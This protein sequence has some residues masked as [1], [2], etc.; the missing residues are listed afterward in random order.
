MTLFKSLV[1]ILTLI[2]LV[3]C[4]NADRES[5]LQDQ[6]LSEYSI[7][8]SLIAFNNRAMF[9]VGEI[10]LEDVKFSDNNQG[11]LRQ[12]NEIQLFFK[13]CSI[14]DRASQGTIR[15]ERFHIK[16]ELGENI[17]WKRSD[18]SSEISN[19]ITVNSGNCLRWSQKVPEFDFYAPSVNIALHFEIESLSGQLGK[20]VKRIG[21][22]PWDMHRRQ[23][24][25]S[26]FFDLTDYNRADWHSGQWVVGDQIVDALKGDLFDRTAELRFDS[27]SIEPVERTSVNVA[28]FNRQA[29]EL[30][31]SEEM[32]RRREIERSL[33]E[34]R[35]GLHINVNM[36]A[37]PVV[38]NYDSGGNRDRTPITS[39]RFKVYMNLIAR[40]AAD[41]NERHLLS[42]NVTDITGRSASFIWRM[43]QD[44]RLITSVPLIL[45][46]RTEFGR[47]EL[48]LKVVPVDSGLRNVKPY[49][50]VFDL[51]QYDQWVRRQ[52]T[53]F[54]FD[55]NYNPLDQ[56]SYDQYVNSVD[57]IVDDLRTVREID[58]FYFGPLRM[59]FIRIMPGET[60]TDRTLQYSVSTCVEHGLYGSRVGPGLQFDIETEDKGRTH[61]MR[62]Q[63]N[64]EGCLVWFGFLSHKFYRKEV[65][66][67]KTA[68]VRFAGTKNN[69]SSSPDNNINQWEETINRY[70]QEFTYYMNPWDEKFTFGWDENEMP[71]GYADEIA[72]QRKTAPVSQLFIAD[73]RYETM[74]F[75]YAIDKYLNLKVKKAVLFKAFPYVL[76][77]NSIVYG[78]MGTQKLRDGVYLMKVALQKD[79]LDPAA[80]GVR[81]YDRHLRRPYQL[82]ESNRQE[83]LTAEDLEAA[84]GAEYVYERYDRE[85]GTVDELLP[86]GVESHPGMGYSDSD[87]D[88]VGD[89]VDHRLLTESELRDTK[90]E[91]IS[92]QTKLVRVLGGMIIT[93]IEFEIDDLRLMRIRN[94]F[95]IQLETIDEHKLRMATV[96]DHVLEDVA[97]EGNL[98]TEFERIFTELESLESLEVESAQLQERMNQYDETV[99]MSEARSEVERLAGSIEEGRNRI[100]GMLGLDSVDREDQELFERRRREIVERFN[101]LRQYR[102]RLQAVDGDDYLA[103]FRNS[104][105]EQINSVLR[106]LQYEDSVSM[107]D[108]NQIDE[109][110]N[111]E[112]GEGQ[113]EQ[114]FVDDP[115]Q[116]LFF[117]RQGTSSD[118][119]M[120][121]LD[122]RIEVARQRLA[123]AEEN[124][125]SDDVGLYRQLIENLETLKVAD[126]TV[127]PLTPSFDFE[128]VVNEGEHN[129]DLP[130]DDG[131]SGLP[132][133]TFV[134]P[135][136]FVFNTNG[137]SLRPTDRLNEA[138]CRTSFCEAPEEMI[139]RGIPPTDVE[140][141]TQVHTDGELPLTS[142]PIY[143]SGD[144]INANYENNKYYGYLKDYHNKTVDMLIEEKK[145]IEEREYR[146]MEEAS[147]IINY[148]KTMKLRYVLLNDNERSRLKGIDHNCAQ[149]TDIDRITECFTD[150]LSGSDILNKGRMFEQLNHRQTYYPEFGDAQENNFSNRA[151]YNLAGDQEITEQN[152]L[153]IM[154]K[155]WRSP[156]I[157]PI[158]V[159][160]FMHRMCFVLA[161]NFFT[162]EYFE[163]SAPTIW[164][165]FSQRETTMNMRGLIHLEKICH[166]YVGNM[167]G[168]F[169][170]RDRYERG[171]PF[172]NLDRFSFDHDD[173]VRPQ[174]MRFSPIVIERKVRAYSTTDRYVYRGG[175]S[176]NINLSASFNLSSSNGIKVVTSANFKPWDW[177]SDVTGALLGRVARN[178]IGGVGISQSNSMDE[179]AG[180][181]QGV[182]VSSGTFLVSQQA[183]LDIELGEYERCLVVRLHPK[184][185]KDFMDSD[186]IKES[187]LDENIDRNNDGEPEELSDILSQGMLICSG[188]I[189]SNRLPIKEKYYYFTQHFTEG[190]MLDTADLH[191]HP[192]L[193]QLRGY[194]DFQVF[195]SMIGAREVQYIDT[196]N[197]AGEVMGR[198]MTDAAALANGNLSEMGGSDTDNYNAQFQ[199]VHQSEDIN[200]PL[201][202]LGRTYF[203]VLPTF[204]GLYTYMNEDGEDVSN[205]PY[206]S[207]DPGRSFAPN[208]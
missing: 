141:A 183:T 59:R 140:T 113:R 203:E 9:E 120:A 122:Y 18:N 48:L 198:T 108:T 164:D 17:L 184:I 129:P 49:T 154:E 186:F 148:T 137:S 21:F 161:E 147:Q 57:G 197:W 4:V 201:E 58:R 128:L 60:A 33:L 193:L 2:S 71:D 38:W 26:G 36:N 77:Y 116:R 145:D 69:G 151:Y 35:A 61:K 95:Y 45:R 206:D 182:T 204:P 54:S 86:E 13:L 82:A 50:A 8:Q 11:V 208:E 55:E 143:A 166:R 88:V 119:I 202:E 85:Y 191:N 170:Q 112:D 1:S 99:D 72:E 39:G 91:F 52:N 25:S 66:Q 138:Y 205:W 64:E 105:R 158:M 74:G 24:L 169:R 132:A 78:R 5:K 44:G 110:Y 121:E 123:Q 171:Q 22:N 172:I 12:S 131:L 51:G 155:G 173:A 189:R 127:S 106:A 118:R 179:S 167:Y 100:L 115:I 153:D 32:A 56:V 43:N 102:Q 34:D 152:I 27:I 42:S 90:K 81:I 97:R 130:E 63:T 139:R 94:Q 10:Q 149:T 19:P 40:G 70:E 168:Y 28:N 176:L 136:T 114:G 75:R 67:K 109:E 159:R 76:K 156:D 142:Q 41:N 175:K 134:G 207:T 68:M 162:P 65:L 181:S 20:I 83:S 117:S 73:F 163:K 124:G 30:L 7:E 79:Y 3:G 157:D 80:K 126:F 84:Y 6:Q 92:V 125:R 62:R 89:S 23:S 165:T 87:D 195:T 178:I 103:A 185:I 146:K 107:I 196:N 200:W 46:N 199:I 174:N 37:Q 15:N 53:S 177:V 14:R 160:R 194:R 47:V 101:R 104:K 96:L 180:R 93:P 192:W 29:D 188:Q 31:D 190:D 111:Q 133:R 144:S 98:E 135:L 150:I 187:F 16:S